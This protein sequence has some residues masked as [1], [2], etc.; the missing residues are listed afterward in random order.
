MARFLS[1]S[2]APLLLR[3][4][5]GLT[6]LWAGAGKLQYFEPSPAQAGRLTDWGVL[7][8]P[9][10][11]A[12]PEPEPTAEPTTGPAEESGE[13]SP[14]PATDTAPDQPAETPAE[15]S[16]EPAPAAEPDIEPVAYQI[17]A[18]APEPESVR[19]LYG[20]AL[21][22][23][24][25]ANPAPDAEGNPGLRL[26]PSVL[27]DGKLPVYFAWGAAV[28]ELVFGAMVLVGFFG[29]LSALPLAGTMLVAA[30][31][32]VIGPAIQSGNALLGFLPAGLFDLK[33]FVGGGVTYAY[34]TFLWQIALLVMA[35]A[36]VLIGPG[37]V[38]IDRML[39]GAGR[40]RSDDDP[41][42]GE[43]DR[44]VATRAVRPATAA[45][46][47]DDAVEFV[48]MTPGVDD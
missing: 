32:T 27:A 28:S 1:L 39:F 7:E 10:P 5:L 36:V 2:L 15:S 4:V 17:A 41:D 25:A 23:D 43:E 19:R 30:W 29:R 45:P 9:M 46:A 44:P 24:G 20:L 22:I 42:Y 35:L 47:D 21:L 33:P 16:P 26:W 11:A 18:V 6:F 37:A 14:D 34:S 12:A 48:K 3:L 13:P 38:S 31:L 40:S 8:G